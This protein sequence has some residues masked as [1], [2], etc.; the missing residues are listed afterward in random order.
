[1]FGIFHLIRGMCITIV[2]IFLFTDVVV[3]EGMSH[4]SLPSQI[5][6]LFRE[7]AHRW[8]WWVHGSLVPEGEPT[9]KHRIFRILGIVTIPFYG[10]QL[11]MMASFSLLWTHHTFL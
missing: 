9:D 4:T 1:M 3:K 10:R 6:T 11:M 5:S 7:H 2:I 8:V